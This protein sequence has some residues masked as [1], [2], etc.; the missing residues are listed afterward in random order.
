MA[1]RAMP[2][3]AKSARAKKKPAPPKKPA[4]KKP[5]AKKK[6]AAA[7]KPAPAK[8]LAAPKK[9]APAKKPAAPKKAAPAKKPAAAKKAAPAKKAAAV[10][11][12]TPVARATRT[13]K[14]SSANGAE[15]AQVVAVGVLSAELVLVEAHE[16]FEAGHIGRAIAGY[17]RALAEVEDPEIFYARGMARAQIDDIVGALSDYDRAI[18]LRPTRSKYWGSRGGV[19]VAAGDHDGAVLDFT[20]AL[21]LEGMKS[22]QYFAWR[23]GA[24]YQLTRYAEAASDF[25]SCAAIDPDWKDIFF[26]Q[27]NA[28]LRAGRAAD[29]EHSFTTDLEHDPSS[30]G[31]FN[32]HL[33]RKQ[34]G[35]R[36]EA[37]DDLSSAIALLPDSFALRGHRGL[38]AFEL[39]NFAR[40][41]DD[42]LRA[43]E[44]ARD[45]GEDIDPKWPLGAGI[46]LSELHRFE[47]ALAVLTFGVEL[48]P[49]EASLVSNRGWAL[50]RLG[51]HTEALVDLDRA[52]ILDPELVEARY[53]RAEA[54]KAAG[55]RAG[56][57]GDYQVLA[58]LR[59]SVAEQIAEL[60]G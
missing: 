27:G 30:M 13:A 35:R 36:E 43:I 2:A 7:K 39:Q 1:L 16:A 8:K 28:E 3:G 5:A 33:A 46:A 26:Q 45:Q 23:G 6:A 20:R 53:H 37:L 40:A 10:N 14:K 32:R 60:G 55:D 58:L 44:L 21:E 19:R 29:A 42:L 59:E 50:Y 51:R 18:E 9:A 24:L 49:D 54:R 52:V 15:R 22:A 34:L 56:A 41:A 38:L 31:H 17:T 4:A 57:L 11:M 12:K 25:A 47:E 48:R